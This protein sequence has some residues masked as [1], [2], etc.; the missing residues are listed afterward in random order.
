MYSV[1][2]YY[3]AVSVYYKAVSRYFKSVTANTWAEGK[4]RFLALQEIC[5]ILV[6]FLKCHKKSLKLQYFKRK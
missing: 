3:K 6:E 4:K 1:I 2:V 5:K